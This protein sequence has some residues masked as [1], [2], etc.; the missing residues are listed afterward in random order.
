M[1]P[2]TPPQLRATAPTRKPNFAESD[3]LAN[4]PARPTTAGER[5]VLLTGDRPVP[6]M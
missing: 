3:R 1:E 2:T 6:G 4:Q 5:E